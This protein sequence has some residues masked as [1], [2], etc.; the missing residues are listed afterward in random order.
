M[1]VLYVPPEQTGSSDRPVDV[2]VIQRGL[3]AYAQQGTYL[4]PGPGRIDGRWGPNT[5]ASLRAWVEATASSQGYDSARVMAP[6]RDLPTGTQSVPLPGGLADL[7]AAAAA[8]YTA[9]RTP[10]PPTTQVPTLPSTGGSRAMPVVFG[11][12]GAAALIGGFAW[13]VSRDG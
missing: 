13:W 11:L 9:P 12:L 6:L 3:A 8:T 7:L 5:L 2:T 4:M 1:T 10:A